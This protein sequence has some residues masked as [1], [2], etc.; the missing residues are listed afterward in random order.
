MKEENKEVKVIP[1]NVTNRLSEEEKKRITEL[2]LK[3]TKSF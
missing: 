2:V 1:L 3:N